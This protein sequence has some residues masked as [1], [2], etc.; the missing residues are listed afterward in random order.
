MKECRQ[1]TEGEAF[2]RQWYCEIDG[3]KPFSEISGKTVG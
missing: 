3:K 2:L 1:S